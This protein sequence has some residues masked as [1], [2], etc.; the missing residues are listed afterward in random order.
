MRLPDVTG[1]YRA[2]HLT[3][4]VAISHRQ[5]L[6]S[7]A[8]IG[9]NHARGLS[10]PLLAW[11][12][13]THRPKISELLPTTALTLSIWDT[14]RKK[15]GATATLS[16]ALQLDTIQLLIP[17]FNYKLWYRHGLKTISQVMQ[18]NKLKSLPDLQTEFQLPSTATF[19][20][21]QMRSWVLAK[22]TPQ[23]TKPSKAHWT[24][25]IKICMKTK[26]AMKLISTVFA[27]EHTQTQTKPPSFKTAWQQ[28][29]GHQLT[30]EQWQNIY[31][32]HKRMTLS[33]TH[34]ELSRKILYR[35]YLT[36]TKHRLSRDSPER[37][38]TQQDTMNT[39]TNTKTPMN[40]RPTAAN[41]ALSA[42]ALLLCSHP[43]PH[44]PIQQKSQEQKIVAWARPTPT[45]TMLPTITTT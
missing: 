8:K 20:Y 14:Y 7:W 33:T 12:P 15:M 5:D 6:T 27:S 42:H 40:T 34:I 16:P 38:Q 26:P 4:L 11:L 45:P 19:S 41:T 21:R 43:S 31:C 35:W 25:I 13:K 2:A 18:G 32:A 39:W 37:R 28:D 29:M 24:T 10:I 30:E 1:Y 22:P 17:D 36:N 9:K 23:Q 44:H 3:P